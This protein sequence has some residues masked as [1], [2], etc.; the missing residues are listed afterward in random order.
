M[1]T[2]VNGREELYAVTAKLPQLQERIRGTARFS[3]DIAFE[4]RNLVRT[5]HYCR[6]VLDRN[7]PGLFLCQ[8]GHQLFRRLLCKR[9]FVD[10]RRKYAEFQLQALQKQFPVW[11]G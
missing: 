11:A 2:Q 5:D 9:C 6:R 10:G 4:D 8:A 7:C 1:A 3:N